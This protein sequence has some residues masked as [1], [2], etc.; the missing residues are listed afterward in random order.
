MSGGLD[1][2]YVALKYK[3]EGAEVIGV[4]AL[5]TKDEN[6]QQVVRNAKD[7]CEF[8][9]IEHIVLDLSS[10][11]EEDVIRYFKE[12]YKNAL[13]PNPC[14]VCNRKIKWGRIKNYAIDELG[15]DFFATGHYACSVKE[16][17]EY[18]IYRAK[19]EK[20]D[21]LYV[22]FGLTQKDLAQTLFPMGVVDKE[23]ARKEC[24][25]KNLPC[26]NSKDSQDVCF[27]P[28]PDTTKK[29]LQREF[30]KMVG[31]FADIRSGKI[32]GSHEGFYL[33]TVGQ[34]KGIGISAPEPLYVVDIDQK[35]NIVYVGY[36]ED[37]YSSS[38]IIRDVN[39]QLQRYNN[40]EFKAMV[41]I[42]YNTSAKPALVKIKE[43]NAEI[44]FDAPVS[45][46]TPG[47]AAVIYDE[48]NTF[49]IGGGWICKKV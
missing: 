4:T 12:S 8:L 40:T 23:S 2:S 49:L 47:Q 15:A 35:K 25:D 34:R 39:L 41:K 27:I 32:V 1:S 30:S 20:K 5:M 11:F 42:R 21:Q 36:K 46:V 43:N 33:Y 18:R 13:T 10:E 14:V 26:K 6:S 19:D 17:D 45:A 29:F 9:N 38:L 16:D 48:K 3:E 44:I 28:H 37:L 22:L 31:D 7:V 24:I